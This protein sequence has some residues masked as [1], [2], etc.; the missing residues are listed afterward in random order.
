M[1]RSLAGIGKHY[2]G[3]NDFIIHRYDSLAGHSDPGSFID[4]KV[5]VRITPLESGYSAVYDG[6]DNSRPRSPSNRILYGIMSLIASLLFFHRL[7]VLGK[8]W[9]EP[10]WLNIPFLFG[11]FLCG[12]YGF[13]V[14]LDSVMQKIN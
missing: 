6:G 9:V 13:G 12:M 8:N 1:S 3:I 2:S 11:A 14:L 10:S 7:L 4:G 5:S